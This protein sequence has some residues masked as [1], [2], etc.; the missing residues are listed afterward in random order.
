MVGE[1]E[2]LNEK[3][4]GKH[5]ARNSWKTAESA[6]RSTMVW[7]YASNAAVPPLGQYVMTPEK[8]K[9]E[10]QGEIKGKLLRKLEQM[11]RDERQKLERQRAAAK[12]KRS[13]SPT[14]NKWLAPALHPEIKRCKES[15]EPDSLQNLTRRQWRCSYQAP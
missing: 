9:D 5:T 8:L 1:K 4:T 10:A 3:V 15:A 2:L 6:I 7:P 11:M 13:D 12:A 14:P